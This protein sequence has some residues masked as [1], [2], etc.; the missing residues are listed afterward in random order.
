MIISIMSPGGISG[1]DIF[2]APISPYQSLGIV[3]ANTVIESLASHA[4]LRPSQPG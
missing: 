2:S 4:W 3:Q 1:K